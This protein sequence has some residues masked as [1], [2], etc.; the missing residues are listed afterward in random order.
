M[1]ETLR[2]EQPCNSLRKAL[3]DY[4]NINDILTGT[5][6]LNSFKGYTLVGRFKFFSTI[7][8]EKCCLFFRHFSMKK[9]VKN[10]IFFLTE[11]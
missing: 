2:S 5:L 11:F 3:K 1:S 7:Y 6:P 8:D 10:S 9:A 4:W